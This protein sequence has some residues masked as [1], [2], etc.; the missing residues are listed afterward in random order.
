MAILYRKSSL[1]KIQ[2]IHTFYKQPRSWRK[3]L[4]NKLTA[5]ACQWNQTRRLALS[6]VQIPKRAA[7]ASRGFLATAWLSCVLRTS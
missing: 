6:K 7:A 3:Y 5:T 1:S 2:T 4:I